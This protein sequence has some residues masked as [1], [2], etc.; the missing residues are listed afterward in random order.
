MTNPSAALPRARRVRRLVAIADSDSYVKWAAALLGSVPGVDARVLLVR[1]P[2]TVSADQERAALEGSGL[3]PSQ[4]E[5]IE[6]GR[7]AQ[8]L[9][10][11]RADAVVLAG[12]GPFVRIVQHEIDR[13]SP[14]PVVVTGL[15]GISIP[16][17]RGAVHY[18]RQADLFLVHSHREL[19]A[20]ADLAT[21]M[22]VRMRFALATLPF[23][24]GREA[25][26]RDGTDLVF[27][28]QA[29]VPR[30]PAQ[31]LE[32]A[33]IL[34]RAALA[35]PDR[36]VVVKLRSRPEV[37]ERET[38]HEMAAYPALFRRFGEIP[39]NVV[40]SYAP[41][42]RALE[43]AEG[44]V[45][46]SSTAAIEAIAKGVPVIAL[47]EFGVSKANL[48]TVFEASGLLGDA[49]DV[50]SRRF[51]TP[52]ARWVTENYFHPET[53]SS[54]LEDVEDLVAAR[55]EGTLAVPPHPYRIG[56]GLWRAWDRKIML[57]SLDRSASGMIALLI[58]MPAR[59]LLLRLRKTRSY[60][61]TFSWA[62]AGS[63]ITLTAAPHQE[64]LRRERAARAPVTRL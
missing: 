3:D 25:R 24:R 28:A 16:A 26:N 17:Q 61:G 21:R 9:S 30:D 38:H 29:V 5:L 1:T 23:A 45:T 53:S 22:D 14:R 13:V 44:L 59:W 19:R 49:D 56:A 34:R 63:D 35:R 54:W 41:M 42:N 60:R 33:A 12:R 36:R 2:V 27:A 55:Q 58:G 7:L 48:N 15:P 46:I 32:L 62:E 47:D 37:G 31:R 51:R 18:R 57:G 11:L 6:Y 8:R 10:V 40:F 39:E 50:V 4:V 43:H 64:P 52:D 20:F